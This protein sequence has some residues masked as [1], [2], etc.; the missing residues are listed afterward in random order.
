VPTQVFTSAMG[1]SMHPGTKN[2]LAG[3]TLF[4]LYCVGVAV[5]LAT[6]LIV[7]IEHGPKV[8]ASLLWG[9]LYPVRLFITDVSTRMGY[10]LH[11][12][13]KST[14]A[15]GIGIAVASALF[16]LIVPALVELARAN[17]RLGRY[18][19][20]AALAIFA[21]LALFWGALPNVF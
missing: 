10:A 1:S 3:R 20:F 9:L 12:P 4:S 8:Y 19:G 11:A 5:C 14:S 18:L 17:N 7:M 21:L 15:T 2:K 16:G 6:Q 13:L